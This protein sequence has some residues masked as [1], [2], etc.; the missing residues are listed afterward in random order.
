MKTRR[1]EHPAMAESAQQSAQHLAPAPSGRFT[2]HDIYLFKEGSH[3]RLHDGL[4]SR[5]ACEHGID[6]SRFAVWA[7]NAARVSVIGDFNG[8]DAE[9]HPLRVR[10]DGS[11]IW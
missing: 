11:G 3:G 10:D 7:P 2:D 5:P 9:S 1:R 8:W 4:G 6:G